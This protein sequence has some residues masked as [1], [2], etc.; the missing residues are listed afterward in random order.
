M[1]K[2]ILCTGFTRE[3]KNHGQHCE[4]WARYTLTG[5]RVKADNIRHDKGTDC[6]DFQIKSARATVCQGLDIITYVET[7]RATRFIYVTMDGAG[8]EMTKAEYITFC[9]TFGTITRDSKENGG[10][11]KIRLK[12]E[13][14]ALIAFLEER[15]RE[16]TLSPSRV[17]YGVSPQLMKARPGSAL[18]N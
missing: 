3:Y 15:A 8:Y 18:A 11:E 2:F 16:Q 12:H 9:Q 17:S 7:E 1:K 6:L 10:R 5:E 13:S 14:R 4:Q